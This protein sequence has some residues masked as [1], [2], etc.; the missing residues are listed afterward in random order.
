MSKKEAQDEINSMDAQE[1]ADIT[2]E[3][4]APP[5]A[6]AVLAEEEKAEANETEKGE[7][8]FVSE[9]PEKEAAIVTVSAKTPID[10]EVLSALSRRMLLN[11]WIPFAVLSVVFAAL[12]AGLWV[13]LDDMALGLSVILVGILIPP[14]M[15]GLVYLITPIRAKKSPLALEGKIIEACFSDKITGSETINGAATR[16]FEF[17]Y[18]QILKARETKDYFFLFASKYAAVVVLKSGIFEGTAAD[19]SNTLKEKLG[20]RFK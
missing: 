16:N 11:A 9:E 3:D 19:L 17:E 14:G 6:E 20:K 1:V 4:V 18:S 8:Q 15:F 2:S 12:G 13:A 5:L 7:P 10:A